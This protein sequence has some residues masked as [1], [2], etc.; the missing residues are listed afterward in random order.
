MESMKYKVTQNFT[1]AF[2]KSKIYKGQI[3][4]LVKDIV[5]EGKSF[6]IFNDKHELIGWIY[7]DQI[8]TFLS[9]INSAEDQRIR[10]AVG[11]AEDAFWAVIAEKF[12]E[13]KGGNLCFSVVLPW[14]KSNEDAVRA[15]LMSNKP[16]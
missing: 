4:E 13:I 6:K 10:I 11:E 16:V 5:Q 14:S 9:E 2:G 12:P 15:W 7:D 1:S 3:V 8:K